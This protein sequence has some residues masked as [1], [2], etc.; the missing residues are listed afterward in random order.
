[1]GEKKK[2]RSEKDVKDVKNAWC[3]HDTQLINC[4][5]HYSLIC[6][7]VKT[8]RERESQSIWLFNCAFYTIQVISNVS[9]WSDVKPVKYSFFALSLSLSAFIPY[10]CFHINSDNIL[11]PLSFTHQT[12][13]AKLFTKLL[14]CVC[15]V[16]A[17][18]HK[19]KQPSSIFIALGQLF[20]FSFYSE[21]ITF[22]LCAFT[23][24]ISRRNFQ[25]HKKRKFTRK[26]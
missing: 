26:K 18:P 3:I 15:L 6:M 21:L 10:L 23:R 19:T 4:Q 2:I 13:F 9:K 11:F 12:Y 7:Y 14:T 25:E 24:T 17:L 5:G 1:M 8:D 22:S 20:L 16:I